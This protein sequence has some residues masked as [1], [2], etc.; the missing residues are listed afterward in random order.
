M[1]IHVYEDKVTYL[2]FKIKFLKLKV[3]QLSSI[4][5]NS[6][7]LLI[8]A[9]A[10]WQIL[11][12]TLKSKIKLSYSLFT[13]LGLNLSTFMLS[14]SL[15]ILVIFFF[16]Q[17]VITQ[18]VQIIVHKSK[19]INLKNLNLKNNLVFFFL[20]N[21][22]ARNKCLQHSLGKEIKKMKNISFQFNFTF[23]EIWCYLFQNAKK[24]LFSDCII[25]NTVLSELLCAEL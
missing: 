24:C 2:G 20:L 7:S 10:Y 3:L 13:L 1:H 23:C 25:C 8:Y 4:Q 14:C 5:L 19:E 12:L 9:Q 22:M 16:N 17:V 21:S 15:D 11:G 6:V 18:Q